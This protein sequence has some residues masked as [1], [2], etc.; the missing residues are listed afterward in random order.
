MTNT[1][2]KIIEGT[3][4][5]VA[6]RFGPILPKAAINKDIIYMPTDIALR[7]RAERYVDKKGGDS[8]KYQLEFINVWLEDILYSKPR[9]RT[10]IAR[11]GIS[12]QYDNATTKTAIKMFKA[13]PAD[14][15][16]SLTMWTKYKDKID[17]FISEFIF[18]QQENPNIEFFIDGDKK[19]EFDVLIDP[20]LSKDDLTV[21]RM[22]QDGKYWKHTYQFLV[23]GWLFKG[24][25]IKTAKEITL[26]AYYGEYEAGVTP[27]DERKLFENVINES[28]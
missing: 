4:I 24:V 10:P 25:A 17:D 11:S 9:R 19:V 15:T 23:E 7:T 27:D 28:S 1:L 2:R 16:F 8:S 21:S 3:V 6:D 20:A 14:L 12:T 5:H 18:W 22:Y 13:V 26:T